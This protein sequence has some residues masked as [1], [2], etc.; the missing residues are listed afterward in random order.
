M[1]DQINIKKQAEDV[2]K[3]EKKFSKVKEQ[4]KA[5]CTH[6]KNGELTLVPRREGGK[7]GELV[8]ICKQCKKVLKFSRIDD[9]EA[10][11]ALDMVDCMI[12]IIKANANTNNENDMDM[13]DKMAKVQYHVRNSVLPFYKASLSRNNNRGNRNNNNNRDRDYAWSKPNTI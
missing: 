1:A 12:D 7:D 4:L 5:K 13:V 8:Y 6:T 11:A 9:S 2:D 3:Q 10:Q